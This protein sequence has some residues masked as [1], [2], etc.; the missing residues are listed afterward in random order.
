M[1]LVPSV[2]ELF[3][4]FSFTQRPLLGTTIAKSF[5]MSG[6]DTLHL[7]P[8]FPTTRKKGQAD[9]PS[10]NAVTNRSSG[11]RRFLELAG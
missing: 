9:V 10:R 1:A 3:L 8:R 4:D 2:R 11:P 6:L 5:R 7:S